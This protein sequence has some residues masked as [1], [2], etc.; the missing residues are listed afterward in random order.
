MQINDDWRVDTDERNVVLYHK[1]KSM[2]DGSIDNWRPVGYYG[3][4]AGALDSLVQ[5]EIFG[6]GLEDLRT[7]NDRLNDISR[8][9]HQALGR[10]R[11]LS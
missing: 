5:R 2:R 8:D 3:T 7:V 6:I 9:I 1:D 4:M 10:I 11:K